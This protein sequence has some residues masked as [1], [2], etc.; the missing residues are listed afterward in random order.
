MITDDHQ[1]N[2]SLGQNYDSKN[3]QNLLIMIENTDIVYN[4][5]AYRMLE[6]GSISKAIVEITKEN[7]KVCVKSLLR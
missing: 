1:L 5:K 6:K 3:L 4:G 2:H 7:R